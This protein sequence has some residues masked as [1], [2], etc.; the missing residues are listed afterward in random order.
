MNKSRR[1]AINRLIGQLEE[2]QTAIEDVSAEEEECYDNLPES[3]R[4]SERGEMMSDAI[5]SLQSAYDACDEVIS[6]LT[7]AIQ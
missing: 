7:D 4:D 1:N 6:S 2:I 3:L 5:E